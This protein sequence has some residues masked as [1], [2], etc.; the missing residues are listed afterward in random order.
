MNGRLVFSKTG[1]DLQPSFPSI[2]VIVVDQQIEAESAGEIPA[3]DSEQGKGN[4]RM[5]TCPVA[6]PIRRE[7]NGGWIRL[8][9]SVPEKD[10]RLPGIKA[11]QTDLPVPGLIRKPERRLNVV[12]LPDHGPG[13]G[14]NMPV[15]HHFRLEDQ[16]ILP[17]TEPDFRGKILRPF[18]GHVPHQGI[19]GK[20]L[21]PILIP[22]QHKVRFPMRFR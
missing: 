19:V 3:S 8:P 22:V 2:A 5:V 14:L 12:P 6:L 21:H 1:S 13:I 16:G 9:G 17:E 15:I 18:P 20:E 4:L 10:F 7:S 11:A